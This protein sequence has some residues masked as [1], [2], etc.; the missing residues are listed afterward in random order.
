[1]LL[2]EDLGELTPLQRKAVESI[3][4]GVNR[5]RALVENLLDVTALSTGNMTFFNREYD[6]NLQ[7]REAIKLCDEQC[8]DRGI[9]MDASIPQTG[10][11]GYGDS[12]KLRRAMVQLLENAAKFCRAEGRV[13]VC[14]RRTADRFMF[15]VYDSGA[16]IPENELR[17][18]FKTFYQIDGS[19]TREHG[20]T[21][22]GLALA[23]KIVERFGGEIWAESPPES[24]TV[25]F[26]WA[27]TMVGL[28]VPVKVQAE[29]PPA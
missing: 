2:G 24:Q 7:A 28:W 15:L 6:F 19:P 3:G 9:R 8:R 25:G 16:G 20:G 17:A 27:R 11:K 1:M 18:I 22:L 26:D 14:T 13:H 10:F 21:G 29:S 5:V 12:D 23:R 4:R